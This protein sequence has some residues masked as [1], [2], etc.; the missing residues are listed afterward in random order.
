VRG[1]HPSLHA[2]KHVSTLQMFMP[3]LDLA[4][5]QVLK[6]IEEEGIQAKAADVGGYL[7]EGL[8][9]LQVSR[10]GRLPLWMLVSSC[11]ASSFAGRTPRAASVPLVDS[12]A[13]DVSAGVVT[14]PLAL[15]EAR[16]GAPCFPKLPC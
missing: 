11:S 13:K 12:E 16:L 2:A 7:L 8:R 5:L 4:W 9:G 3:P 6:V 15:L 10:P 14:P 1:S